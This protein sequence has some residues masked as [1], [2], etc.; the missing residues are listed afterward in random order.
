MISYPQAVEA[1][2][3]SFLEVGV[4][5]IETDTFRANRLT[6][7]DYGLAQRTVE[8]NRAAAEL[9]RRL[10]NEY[11]NRLVAGSMGPSGKLPSADDPELSN[12]TFE[13][14]VDIF[15]E[16]AV[17]LIQEFHLSRTLNQ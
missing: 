8:I 13:E 3:R 7:G 4:D 16:Q 2:H 6:L 17:G 1:V 14:L 10:A 15:R 5:V 9:A 11:G 12:I